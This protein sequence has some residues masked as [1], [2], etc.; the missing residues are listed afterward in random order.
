ME[1]DIYISTDGYMV[2]KVLKMEIKIGRYYRTTATNVIKENIYIRVDNI[3]NG[4]VK[5]TYIRWDTYPIAIGYKS[6][7][8][9]EDFIKCHKEV[10]YMNTPLYKVLNE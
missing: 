1:N 3:T 7:W 8:E 2:M 9:T 5:F 10:T 4:M 6:N